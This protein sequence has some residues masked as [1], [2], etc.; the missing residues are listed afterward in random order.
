M[1][2]NNAVQNGNLNLALPQ[3]K[4]LPEEGFI[5]IIVLH[6]WI[7]LS[8][9]IFFLLI[10]FAYL[11]KAVPIYTSFSRLYVEQTGPKIIGDYE[12]V[13][14][15][16]KNY[17]YT[18]GELMRSTPIISN[19][20]DTPGIKELKTFANI[21]NIVGCI[22]GNLNVDIGK[23]DDI[24]TVFFNSPYPAETAQIVNEVVNSYIDYHA[25]HKRSTVFEVLKILQKE[26]V[27]RDSELSEKFAQMLDFTRKNGVVSFEKEGGHVI[28]QKLTKLSEALT[29]VQLAAINAKADYEATKSMMNEPAKIKQFASA[30]ASSGVQIF[31]NDSETQLRS[32][33]KEAEVQLKNAR[34]YCTENH[35]TVRVLSA[36]I[37]DLK[38]QFNEGARE[39]AE[40]YLEVT[41]LKWETAKQRENELQASYDAQCLASQELGVKAAEYSILQSELRR[42]ERLCEILDNR[43]KELNVTEDTGALNITILEVARPAGSP[44]K[45]QKAKVMTFALLLGLMFGCGLAILRDLIDYRLRSAEEISALLGVPV[46]GVVPTMGEGHTIVTHSQKIWSGLKFFLT[47]IDKKSKL[48]IK[49]VLDTKTDNRPVSEETQP[50]AVERGQKILLKPRS[51]AAEAYRTIRTAVFFGVPKGQAKTILVTSPAPGDGKS[52]LASN[53]AIAMAQAGQKTLVIDAD[54]R[55]P[56]QQD[57]FQVD[58]EKG[59]SGVLAGTQ[60]VNEAIQPGP[61]SGLD[62]LPCGPETPN[63]S[64]ILNSDVFEKNLEELSGRYDRIIIDSPPVTPVA[65]SQILAAISDITILVLR[66]EKST[67]RQ[68]QAARESLLSVGGR[69]LGAVVNDVPRKGGRY[70][71]YSKYGHYGRYGHYGYYYGS[72]EKKKEPEQQEQKAYI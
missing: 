70:G 39:F 59:L 53:L 24:I 22:R 23:R 11:L 63:P 17:L 3:L 10:A 18:Q 69:L 57:I 61:V 43:I 56:R 32:E 48:K 29:D 25:T 44:S 16:A 65:D 67:R 45:P 40:A 33:L 36:R 5:H 52:T 35:P 2:N 49:S 71:Y 21:D 37:D 34:Y 1:E 28:F 58:K 41:R 8:T 13:M 51:I 31:V 47:K 15:Q 54:L 62:I 12:G 6:R 42:T 20:A 46:L 38:Q 14:T 9:V 55:K 4:V 19:V 26:K 64:E 7:I 60:T 27:K 66:A 50:N 72:R 30:S 68:S